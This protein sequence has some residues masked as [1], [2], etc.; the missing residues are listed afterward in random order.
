V[1]YL[2]TSSLDCGSWGVSE[3]L[4]VD[5]VTERGTIVVRLVGDL[6]MS[7][8]EH[9][10]EVG[11]AAVS[12]LDGDATPVVL[13]VSELAFC[14]SFGLRA[15]LIVATTAEAEGHQVTLRKP[16]KMLR[17]MLELVDLRQRF[18]IDD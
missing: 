5:V 11:L 3:T 17:R 7:S 15:L 14:D 18:L 9:V 10:E 13:D 4:L 16:S 1:H 6:D 8:A 12:R 2:V